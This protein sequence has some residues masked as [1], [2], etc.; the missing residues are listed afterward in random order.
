M[1]GPDNGS[2][3]VSSSTSN[4]FIFKTIHEPKYG[5]H[6][7]SGNREFGFIAN[8]NGSIYLYSRVIDRLTTLEASFFQNTTG[9][10]FRSSDI[11]WGTFQ[12][13]IANFVNAHGGSAFAD[14][15]QILRPIWTDVLAVLNGSKPLS[16]IAKDCP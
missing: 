13:E 16:T 5:D 3:V 11:L 12:G 8:P 6:P 10:P 1:P 7:V 2:V 14:E 15:E 9:I 4:S